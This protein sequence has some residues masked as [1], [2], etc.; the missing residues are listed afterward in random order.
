MQC[1]SDYQVRS[2]QIKYSGHTHPHILNTEHLLYSA[3]SFSK[4]KGSRLEEIAVNIQSRLYSGLT[5]K[6]SLI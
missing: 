6:H 5:Y 1:E 3:A 4:P 2:L